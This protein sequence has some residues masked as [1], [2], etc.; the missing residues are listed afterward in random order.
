MKIAYLTSYFPMLTTTFIL[1]EVE[2]HHQAGADILP[3][4]CDPVSADTPMSQLALKWKGPTVVPP[5]NVARMLAVLRETICQPVA[6][7]TNVLWLIGLLFI[8]SREFLMGIK[9]LGSAAY[10]ASACRKHGT[11]LIHVHFAS[12]CLTTG[13]MLGRLICRPVSCTGHAFELWGRSGPNL[14]YRMKHC[15]FVAAI[16]QYNVDYLRDKCGEGIAS[17]CRVIHCGIDLSRF[18]NR[19]QSPAKGEIL[20]VSQ[21][22]EKKGHRYLVEACGILKERGVP[23]KCILIG[24]G[25]EFEDIQA[26]VRDRQLEDDVEL[27]GA[28]PN[29][30][31]QPYLE[32]ASIFTLPAVVGT[33]GDQDGIPVALMEAMAFGVPVVSTMVSGIPEL[34]KDGK[35]GCLVPPRNADA[36]ADAL[37]RLLIDEN[38]IARLTVEGRKSVEEGFDIEKTS[39]Q[40]REEFEV[41]RVP[42]DF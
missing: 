19:K 13:I 35:A 37:Q 21:M 26:L 12:R 10:L 20:L 14:R 28:L 18:S 5:G 7:V 36:L 27:L 15:A 9:E 8:D 34:M 33:G 4:S 22:T 3:L 16:S 17:L 29:D 6:M 31:I 40:L 25:P 1:N 41:F 24:S 2:A 23:N 30:Q 38:E 32:R 11:E 39:R 42:A